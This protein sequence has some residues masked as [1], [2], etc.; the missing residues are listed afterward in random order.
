MSYPKKL[1]NLKPT[2]GVVYDIPPHEVGPDFYTSCSNVNFRNGFAERVMGSRAIY[3]TLPTAA[4]RALNA[5]MGGTNWWLIMG[6]DEVHALETTNSHDIT[7]SG[8]LTAVSAP[9]EWSAGLLNGVPVVNN[10]RDAPMYWDGNSGNDL[11]ALPDWPAG[12]I[13]KQL[14]PFRY[15]LVALDIDGPSGPLQHQVKWSDAAEPGTIPSSWTPSSSNEAGDAELSDTPGPIMTAV[16]L[17]DSL[18]IYKR[19]SVYSMDYIGGTAVFAI[20]TLLTSTGALTRHSVCEIDGRHFVVT[21]RDIIITDGTSINSVAA[22]RMRDYLFQQLDQTN[23]ENLFVIYYKARQEVWVCFP[24]TGNS[25]C[26]KALVYNIATDSFGERTLPS[27]AH[28]ALGIVNDDQP[29]GI[30]DD[31]SEAWDTDFSVWS[32]VNYSLAATGLVTVGGTT[33]TL[34]DTT[35]A[36]TV[37]ASV[38]KYDL[39]FNAPERIKFVKR[40]HLLTKNP[41]TLFVRVGSRM[42]PTGPIRWS[43][44][45][46]FTEDS[47]VVNT[48]AQGRYIS[49]EVR[50]AGEELW[51]ITGINI[52]VE[53]RGY[54]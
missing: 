23:Y 11:V 45:V 6:A 42:A 54:H 39:S 21:D 8:G 49:I 52:E 31:D 32:D 14:V 13:C 28:A 24:E 38:G 1:L 48:F 46:T 12:T 51:A 16:P 33:M 5:D 7:P 34:H 18:L 27:V 44:E 15:H 40:V 35:D 4:M 43:P 26:T 20:R 10:G 25:A 29:S 37:A 36:T 30:W 3:G 41:G 9:W 2:R 22:G 53:M 19:N 17:R 50:S 47:Q